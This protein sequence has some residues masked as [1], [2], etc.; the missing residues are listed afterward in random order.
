MISKIF[1]ISDIHF[2]LY[3]RHKEFNSVLRNFILYVQKHADENSI[4]FIG[5]DVVHSKTEM[6]PELFQVVSRFLKDCA[7]TCTTVLTPGNHDGLVNN[8]N[9]IDALTPVVDAMNHPNLYF[10]KDS[11]VYELMGTTF[12]LFGIFDSPDNWVYAKDI[13]SEFK[14]ALHHGP[15]IGSRTDLITIQHG[16]NASIFDGFDIVMLGDIHMEQTIQE[17][18]QKRGKSKTPIIKYSGSSIQQDHGESIDKHGFLEWNVKKREAKL[19]TLPNEF[20]YYT[21]Y[22]VNGKCDIPDYLPKNLRVRIKHENTQ[23]HQLEDFKKQLSEKYRIVELSTQKITTVLSTLEA[24]LELLGDSRD[25]EYQN[26]IMRKFLELNPQV[27]KEE[28]EELC[29]LNYELNKRLP[30]QNTVRNMAWRP[31]KLEFSNMFSY[32]EGNYIDFTDFK[33][34]Y[35]IFAKNYSGKSALFDI[36]T[37]VIFDKSTRATKAGHVLNNTKKDFYAKF[38][39]ELAGQVYFI[40]RIGTLNEKT[41]SVKVDVNFWTEEDGIE[42]RLNREDRDKT[43]FAI[44]DFLGTYDDFVMVSMSTQYDN[45]N[46]VDTTQKDRKE[47]LYKFL[48]IFIYD[49]LFK[50]AKEESKEYQT[51]LKELEKDDLTTKSSQLSNQIKVLRTE[52]NDID[53][54]IL[55]AETTLYE[56]NDQIIQLSREYQ[57]VD[58]SQNISYIKSQIEYLTNSR[59]DAAKDLQVL[60]KNEEEL[61]AQKKELQKI[62]KKGGTVNAYSDIVEKYKDLQGKVNQSKRKYEGSLSEYKIA[63]S[64]KEHLD[65]HEYDPNCKYCTNNQFVIDAQQ[66]ITNMPKLLD[67]YTSEFDIHRALVLK[68]EKVENE[69]SAAKE[70]DKIVRELEAVESKMVLLNTQKEAIR[71]KGKTC[72][73]SIKEWED[74]EIEYKKNATIIEK[75]L[76]I[77]KQIQQLK[78]RYRELEKS[79]SELKKLSRIKYSEVE[80]FEQELENCIS[81]LDKYLLYKKKNRIYE[82]YLQTMSREGIPYKIVETVLPVIENE[83][84]QI[85]NQIVDFTVRLEATDEKYIHGYIVYPPIMIKDQNG[86]YTEVQRYWPI[87]LTSGME[88]FILS[89]AFRTSLS[90][91]TT[92]PKTNF[93][94]IDEGFGVLDQDNIITMGKLFMYLKQQYEF[95]VVISHIETMKDLVDKNIKIEKINGYSKLEAE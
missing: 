29:N 4:I 90:E 14:I 25:V 80:R 76:Q 17:Y 92:L 43:N 93:L 54:S 57:K 35:G 32:G 82:I 72:Q 73:D 75:N 62:I 6:S 45:Q 78:E 59:D 8:K 40:E 36:L 52:L 30:V 91:I 44:R 69:L 63:L 89:L 34:I 49:D 15:I 66:A 22:L 71:Y 38:S 16:V 2:R 77:E 20:G 39:F 42:I 27:D 87:E 9:R 56:Y 94:A 24:R 79:A 61:L 10:W 18:N 67:A 5:G 46:F 7:D 60:I 50:I 37:F 70:F 11:G 51:L 13:E 21:F 33:G 28:I 84:N 85:L 81:K 1:H 47:L 68:L 65:K 74:K 19:I 26:G 58:E 88:R 55:E 31:L 41:G 3:Q 86:E 53:I 83:V 48:D 64:K 12:S 23:L 95:L